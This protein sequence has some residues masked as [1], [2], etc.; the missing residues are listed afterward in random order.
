MWQWDLQSFQDLPH[1]VMHVESIQSP[2]HRMFG[3]IQMLRTDPTNCIKLKINAGDKVIGNSR[4]KAIGNQKAI[5]PFG[6]SVEHPK[7]RI[8][9]RIL[10]SN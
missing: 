5:A 10:S 4:D 9:F 7:W 8:F 2:N 6:Y 3:I 1:V